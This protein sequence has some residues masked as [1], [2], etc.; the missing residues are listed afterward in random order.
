MGSEKTEAVLEFWASAID[1]F[2]C[3]FDDSTENFS[4]GDRMSAAKAAMRLA[5]VGA[6][7]ATYFKGVVQ[8]CV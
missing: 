6:C 5:Q 7:M 3:D 4:S 2:L 8:G 1:A